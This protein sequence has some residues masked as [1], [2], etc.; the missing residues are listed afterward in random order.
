M[1][2]TFIDWLKK[3]LSHAWEGLMKNLGTAI[4][5]FLLSGGYLIAINKLQEFQAWVRM[6]PTDYVLTP[7]V[8]L[9][10]ITGALWRINR[11]QKQ[12]LAQIAQ[13]PRSDEKEA[14]F[15]THF[16]VWWKLYPDTE[17]IED[18]PY[19]PCCE[20]HMKLVQTEW[21]PEEAYKCPKTG[22]AYKLYDNV[23]RGKGQILNSLYTSYF[24]G[25][26]VRFRRRYM[27]ELGKLKELHPELSDG[28]IT[29]RLFSLAPLVEI[30]EKERQNIIAK[31]ENPIAAFR[32]VERNFLS[33]KKYF[34]KK[35]DE[36]KKNS[37]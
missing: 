1:M 4:A 17:Y 18:F 13:Q 33:Y 24:R 14:R 28:E 30:P 26:G 6:V 29:S 37:G 32:F 22:V 27:T 31:H 5:A 20:P 9:V 16:G 15:V 12:Q 25:L 7:F 19:C 21:H 8:L 11:K 3:S 34:K 2:K 36:G 35:A 10:V 23:P